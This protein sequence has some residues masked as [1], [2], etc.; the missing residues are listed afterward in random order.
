[1]SANPQISRVRQHSLPV[2][3]VQY[4]LLT[5][6]GLVFL[7]P[8]YWL[9]SSALKPTSEIYTYPLQLIPTSLFWENFTYAWTVAPFD[10]YMVNSLIV[11]A[12]GA[13]CKIVIACLTSYAFTFLRFPGRNILFLVMLTALMVP[14]NVTI[15]V[16]YLTV[17]NLGWLN[18][19]A[20]LII[21]GAGSV[22]G[23]FLLRQHM[24]TLPGEVM[25]A[26]DVDGAGHIRRL[27]QIVLP[28]SIPSVVTVGL[29]AVVDEWNGFI[30]PL[31]VTNTD[32]M[33][34]LPIGLS[35]LKAED[36]LANW[37]AVMAGTVLVLLPMLILFLLAQRLI[38]GG[39]T[40]GAVKG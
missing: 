13:T 39:L 29:I 37:G 2:R 4:V 18:T 21:P 11:T 15:I 32:S 33:R 24:M 36:G 30:W 17:A 35:F 8:L 12:V 3:I 19:Y 38:V 16:N 9:F 7:L 20:G 1:M 23:T 25:D 28:M 40:Q 34:T 6:A 31:L 14:G 22:F 26:A 27:W 10:K 5:F